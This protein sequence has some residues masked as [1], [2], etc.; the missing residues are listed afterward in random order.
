M[1]TIQ[2]SA[3]PQ[4]AVFNNGAWTTQDALIQ[5]FLNASCLPSN[6]QDDARAVALVREQFTGVRVVGDEPI[7]KIETSEEE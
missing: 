5:R 6:P 4:P 7:R 2:A 1:I 3:W